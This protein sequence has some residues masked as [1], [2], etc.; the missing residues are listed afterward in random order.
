ML[1]FDPL[2]FIFSRRPIFVLVKVVF[3]SKKNVTKQAE[4]CFCADKSLCQQ[5]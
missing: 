1:R 2:L 4:A 5:S 3:R